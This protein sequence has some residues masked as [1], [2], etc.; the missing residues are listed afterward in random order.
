MEKTRLE[1]VIQYINDGRFDIAMMMRHLYNPFLERVNPYGR[2]PSDVKEMVIKEASE[3]IFYLYDRLI[4]TADVGKNGRYSLMYNEV[5]VNMLQAAQREDDIYHISPRQ[6]YATQTLAVIAI[7][8][9][10]KGESIKI[11]SNT[12]NSILKLRIDDMVDHLPLYVRE[13]YYKRLKEMQE[14]LEPEI[15]ICDEYE[16]IREEEVVNRILTHEWKGKYINTSISDN[17]PNYK[18]FCHH[19]DEA[20]VVLTTKEDL[21]LSDEWVENM[22]MLLFKDERHIRREIYLKRL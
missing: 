11:I 10:L 15:L 12:K 2:I 20:D 8:F 5:A 7:W 21:N 22:S 19:Y 17:T 13:F 9:T 4:T 1:S 16:H 6:T 14:N 18:L 3:N